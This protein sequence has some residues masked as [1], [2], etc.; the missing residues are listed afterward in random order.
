MLLLWLRFLYARLMYELK[1]G[2]KGT[3]AWG[4]GRR[5]AASGAVRIAGKGL[6]TYA[7]PPPAPRPMW[8]AATDPTR[9]RRTPKGFPTARP[10]VGAWAGGGGG[11]S[12]IC[13]CGYR[14]WPNNSLHKNQIKHKSIFLRELLLPSAR[15]LEER[16]TASQ[17]GSQSGKREGRQAGRNTQFWL[18]SVADYS[19]KQGGTSW[20]P[21][22]SAASDST[23]AQQW[24]RRRFET[25]PAIAGTI[26]P[27]ALFYPTL[28]QILLSTTF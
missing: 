8:R 1:S 16:L 23:L 12:E 15:R 26:D 14:K 11:G 9:R 20:V 27:S 10:G 13:G 2:R 22:Q 24:A 6:A 17:S 19:Y 28:V 5:Q 25:R 4:A 7:L 3:G 21:E 18:F